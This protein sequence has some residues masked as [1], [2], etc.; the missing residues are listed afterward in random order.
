MPGPQLHAIFQRLSAVTHKIREF[1]NREVIGDRFETHQPDTEPADYLESLIGR[2]KAP[3]KEP[4][5]W[6]TALFALEDIIGA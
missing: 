3:G 6:D 2:V 5:D 4:L 1:I